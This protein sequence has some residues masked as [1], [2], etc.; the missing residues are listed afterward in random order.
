MVFIV[1]AFNNG[2]AK[3]KFVHYANNKLTLIDT[4]ISK[5]KTKSIRL[6]L[7]NK[8]CSNFPCICVSNTDIK[9]Y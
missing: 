3:K 4:A 1:H 5:I 8:F 2:S 9:S 6:L 7:I